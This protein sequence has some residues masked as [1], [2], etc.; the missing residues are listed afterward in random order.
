MPHGCGGALGV[1]CPDQHHACRDSFRAGSTPPGRESGH[2]SRTTGQGPRQPRLGFGVGR[3]ARVPVRWSPGRCDPPT[4]T[5]RKGL[6][7]EG[8]PGAERTA[9]ALRPRTSHLVMRGTQSQSVRWA[10][11][12]TASSSARAACRPPGRRFTR[13]A[14]GGP[15]KSATEAPGRVRREVV[16]APA[17]HTPGTTLVAR[18]AFPGEC[19]ER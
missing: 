13:R 17:P 6:P 3:V 14:S 15:G 9:D 4:G 16:V 5:P 2:F 19:C 11:H 12:E 10:K 18:A 7:S 8:R 1:A